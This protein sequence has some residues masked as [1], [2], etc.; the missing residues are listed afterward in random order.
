MGGTCLADLSASIIGSSSAAGSQQPAAPRPPVI[1]LVTHSALAAAVSI[2]QGT[3]YT[4]CAPGQQP[5]RQLPCELGATALDSGGANL[6]AA[7]LACPPASCLGSTRCPQALFSSRGL[8]SCSI[9]TSQA[10]GTAIQV[11]LPC[12]LAAQGYIHW[13]CVP[14]PP[15]P[16]T[17]LQVQFV[18]WGESQPALNATATRT[19]VVAPPCD[20]GL[21][22]CPP[23][24]GGAGVLCS[25]VACS[26]LSSLAAQQRGPVVALVSV[27]AARPPPAGPAAPPPPPLAAQAQPPPPPSALQ[28]LVQEQTVMIPYG[29][30]AH[31]SLLPCASAADA[32]AGGCRAVAYDA[33]VRLIPCLLPCPALLTLPACGHAV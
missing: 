21:Y 6:T 16:Y 22:A 9:D 11:R 26:L 18:A 4:A 20:P 33:A 30:P 25:S 28:Q 19:I 29:Q 5:T 12:C 27:A 32:A 1:Q 17:L 15:A 7:V 2:K 8:A 24:T 23:L 13:S 14:T 10:V 31:Q 3:Q